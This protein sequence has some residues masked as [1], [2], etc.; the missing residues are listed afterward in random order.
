MMRRFLRWLA[1]PS[2]N[3][4]FRLALSERE[5]AFADYWT[6]KARGDTRALHQAARRLREATTSVVR[7]EL[8]R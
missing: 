6:A 5:Q 1:E 8:G 7:L 2:R 4:L 3:E